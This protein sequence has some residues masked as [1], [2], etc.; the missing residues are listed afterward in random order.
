M[1]PSKGY[2][3]GSFGKRSRFTKPRGTAGGRRSTAPDAAT[4]ATSPKPSRPSRS[5]ESFSSPPRPES[6]S[7]STEA[8]E[9]T[10]FE[11]KITLLDRPADLPKPTDDVRDTA[12]NGYRFVDVSAVKTLVSALLC[13]NCHGNE[14]DLKES[15]VGAS[16]Q[17]V[18]V[19]RACGDIMT[20]PQSATVGET[21]QSELAARLCVVGK[22]CGISF[23]KLK[24]LFGGMNAPSPMHLK[25]YQNTAEKVHKASMAAARDVMQEAA[26][27]VRGAQMFEDGEDH[28]NNADDLLDICV[29]YDGTW[30]KRGHTSNFGVG[31]VIKVNTGLVLDF[32]VHSKYCHGCNLGPKED[33]EGYQA[34]ME[35]HKDVCQKNFGGSSNAM[36]VAAAGVIFSRS[37]ELHKLQYVTMLSDGDS[38]A[39]TH[40][41]GLGVYDKDIQKEDCVNHVAKRMYSGMEKLKK[42]KKGLGGKGKLTNVMMRKLTYYYATALKDN[43]PDVTKMQK[44][45]YASLLHSYSTDEAPRHTACPSGEDSWCHY[46]CH[47]AL[48]AAGK[49]SVPRPH[50][51][52]FTRDIAKELVPIY[53]R[54]SDRSLLQRCCRMKTQNANES[55]NALIWKRCPKT[56]LASLRTV[57]TAVAMAVLE[58]NLGPKGFERILKKMGICPGSHH[59][60]HTRKATQQKI[61]KAKVKALDT[62]NTTQKRRKLEAITNEQ[63]RIEEEGPT[64]GAGE[65]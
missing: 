16:L 47:N 65:F 25:T 11:R 13:P 34:W 50:R 7:A 30:Q 38:K 14:L 20:T 40:V 37:L 23:T 31:A 35:S 45:V 5:P 4:S 22:D 63:K 43:A 32:S 52:A 6:G 17:F 15:G 24:N 62:S 33:A 61:L 48:V 58:Y 57:E 3:H 29:S 8:D 21:R 42:S 46:N 18:V 49:P 27:A 39:Y 56:E 10:T 59:E 9:L 64:Y 54:L 51:P 44:G 41:A 19:C 36:E 12:L 55:F 28:V 60:E 2:V 1:T 26:T 53:N